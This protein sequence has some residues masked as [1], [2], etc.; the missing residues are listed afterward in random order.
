MVTVSVLGPLRAAV[1]DRAA[2]LGGRRQRAVL[3]RL[4]VAAGSPVSADLLVEDIWSGEPPPRALAALQ[5]HISH[6]RRILEPARPPRAPATVL[7][8][9]APGYALRLDDDALDARRFTRLLDDAAGRPPEAAQGTLR[10]ALACW[11]GP[12][13]G[14]FADEPWAAPEAARL[15]ELRLQAVERLAEARLATGEDAAVVPDLDRHVHDHPLREPAVRLLALALYRAGRQAD[16]LAVLA[17]VRRRLADELG[18]DPG[19]PLQDLERDVLAQAPHLVVRS[20]PAPAPMRPAP[21][22]PAPVPVVDRTALL[23]RAAELDRLRAAAT[24]AGTPGPQVVLVSADAGVGKTTLVE[25]F[26]AELAA[27]GWVTVV[28]RCPEAEGAPPGWPWREIVT[29]LTAAHPPAPELADRLAPLLDAGP[30][31]RD[32]T[33]WLATAVADLLASRTATAPVLVVLEDLHRADGESLQLLRTV[34]GGLA[35]QRLLVVATL[36]PTEAGDDLTATFAALAGPIGDRIE[37][38]GLDPDSVA[39][40]LRRNGSGALTAE[41]VARVVDRT[42]GNP[43]FV[44]ETARLAAAEGWGTAATAVPAGVR[45]VLRRRLARLPA[46]ARTVLRQAAILGRDVD[47]DTLLALVGAAGEDEA[48]DALELGVLSGLLTEPDAGRVRFAHVLVRDTLYEDMPRLRRTRA[49]A[50]ALAAVSTV[51]PGDRSALAHHALAAGAAVDPARAVVLASDAARAAAAAGAHRQAAEL[52]AAVADRADAAGL[53]REA[54]LDVLCAHVSALAHSGATGPA[55]RRRAEALDLALAAPAV[56][57]DVLVR[58]VNCYDAPVSWT[59]RADN[60]VDTRLVEVLDGLLA[61]VPADRVAARVRLL[62]SLVFEIEGEQEERVRELTAQAL[63]LTEGAATDTDTGAGPALRCLALNARF[64]AIFGPDLWHEMKGV[65][66]ELVEVATRAGLPGYRAQGLHLLFMDAASERDL[67]AAQR[68]VD[69]AVAAAPG[70]QL[71]FTLG[72]S[73]IFSAL[74]ALVAGEFDAAAAGYAEIGARLEAGGVTNAGLIALL[75]GLAVAHARGRIDD[76]LVAVLGMVHERAPVEAAE[77]YAL[78]LVLAGDLGRARQVWRPDVPQRRTYYWQLGMA[79]RAETAVALGDREVAGE[80]YDALQP[81]A[82]TF[83]GLSSGTVT[84]G[85]VD[86]SLGRLARLL[87]LP[88]DEHFRAAAALARG[89]GAHHW[90]ARAEAALAAR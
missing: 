41:Q 75:G 17:R 80:C 78:A 64:Y 16:A 71:G 47:V 59:L 43:L 83:A 62:T 63:A 44:R 4:A 13:Y 81:W 39:E 14:E 21:P 88:A 90:A 12:A 10:A 89:L 69:D 54:R 74:R 48:L 56:P 49:H 15:E 53:D 65:G 33:F 58:V 18:V 40:L 22:P 46:Q 79:M 24:R 28:G 5:V 6:L 57:D 31:T 70:G 19:P 61:R 36:R 82:G 7:V 20:A 30:V 38:A 50:A 68:H 9:V 1:D 25:A 77:A 27:G 23:G 55:V 11:A 60:T 26:R 87:G 29:S 35:G 86:E 32:R 72:W 2:D 45:D 3:A 85:P 8:S 42:D 34:A 67:D 37:L 73:A 66:T 84:L 76:Q 52:W 51:R